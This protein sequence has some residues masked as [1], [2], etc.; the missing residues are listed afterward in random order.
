MPVVGLRMTTFG[1][2]VTAPLL[3]SNM[4][5]SEP[6]RLSK[7]IPPPM[8]WLLRKTSS[9]KLVMEHWSVTVVSMTFFFAQGEMTSKGMTRTVAAA[10]LRG[11]LPVT[12]GKSG[13]GAVALMQTPA[14]LTCRRW[15]RSR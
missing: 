2:G 5:F 15:W 14:P 13:R 8:R 11:A 10:S 12:T 6:A 7:S 3:K 9:M 1:L 4:L